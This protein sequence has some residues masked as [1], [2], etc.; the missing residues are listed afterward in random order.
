MTVTIDLA[1]AAR[2]ALGLVALVLLTSIGGAGIVAAPVTLP[3]LWFAGR[4]AS[5][6]LRTF[7]DV[8]AVLTAAEVGWAFGYAAGGVWEWAVP[9]ATAATV[10]VAY[11]LTQRRASAAGRVVAGPA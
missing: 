11:P 8:V 4:H 6:T 7:L 2:L 1:R 5:R 3:L 10:A 9:F